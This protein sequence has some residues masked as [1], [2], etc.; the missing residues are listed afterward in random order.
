MDFLKNILKDRH[1]TVGYLI[2]AGSICNALANAILHGHVS[3]DDI[4]IVLAAA[5]PGVVT[6]PQKKA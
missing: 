1:K 2:L 6:I 5:M 4:Y 3:M